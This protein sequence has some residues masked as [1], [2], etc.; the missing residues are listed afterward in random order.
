LSRA[1][2]QQPQP[3][4]YN[5]AVGSWAGRSLFRVKWEGGKSELQRAVCRIT[6]GRLASRS[7]DGKCHRKYTAL[8]L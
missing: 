4:G 6:S 5:S 3:E 8:S 2:T 7:A 1:K